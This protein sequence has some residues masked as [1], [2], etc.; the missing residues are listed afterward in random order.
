MTYDEAVAAAEGYDPTLVLRLG[1]AVRLTAAQA[2]E[3]AGL[4]DTITTAAERLA[5]RAEGFENSYTQAV[6]E[7]HAQF[8]A[9]AIER[10]RALAAEARAERAETA[11]REIAQLPLDDDTL[12]DNH[13]EWI[14]PKAVT[15]A[16]K[17]LPESEWAALAPNPTEEPAVFE[18]TC[19]TC[20]L[21]LPSS[22]TTCPNPHANPT[23]EPAG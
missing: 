2:A 14:V 10:D 5:K 23:E 22:E 20:G 19:P 9:W 6:E 16:R 13:S 3:L 8:N 1:Y 11:L 12:W 17:V 4:V 7:V 21:R 15:I 18:W